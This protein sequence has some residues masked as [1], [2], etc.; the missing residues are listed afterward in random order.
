MTP[1]KLYEINKRLKQASDDKVK[2]SI[3]AEAQKI[4]EVSKT[5]SPEE[6][7]RTKAELKAFYTRAYA[8]YCTPDKIQKDAACTNDLMK[9]MYGKST[10]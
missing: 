1:C 4:Y 9:K 5:K 8:S 10:A 2:A 3:K 6:R 7:K